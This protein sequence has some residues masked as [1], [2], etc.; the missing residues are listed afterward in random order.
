MR[1][2]EKKC[3]FFEKKFAGI[4]KHRTFALAIKQQVKSC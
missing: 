4:K 3:Y 2:F 1:F